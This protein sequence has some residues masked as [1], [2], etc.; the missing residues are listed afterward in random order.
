MPE[1][2]FQ[3]TSSSE[4][5]RVRQ[6]DAWAPVDLSLVQDADGWWRPAVSPTPVKFAGGGST[7][8]S[9]MLG[10]RGIWASQAWKA[11]SLPAPTVSGATLTYPEVL[12]GVDLAM[13][14][15][16]SGFS[17]V[18]VVKS[19]TAAAN[20]ALDVIRLGLSATT[21][22]TARLVGGGMELMATDASPGTQDDGIFHVG[23]A[24]WWDSATAGTGIH[25]PGGADAEHPLDATYSTS[26]ISLNT[27]AVT[28]GGDVTYPLYL[29]PSYSW[30]GGINGGTAYT[31]VDQ[32]YPTAS[33][34]N[35]GHP[36]HLQ[37]VGYV[38]YGDGAPDRTR[39]FWRMNT[40]RVIGKHVI[41]A[42][43]NTTQVWAYS[44][45]ARQVN[46]YE[47]SGISS[48]T[49]WNNQPTQG[50][51]QST[52]NVAYGWSSAGL[53]GASSCSTGGH[54]VGFAATAAV[55]KAAAARA[56]YT[57]LEL[58]AND[59]NDI[60]GWKK[61][62][63]AATLV[64]TY[65]TAPM[66]PNSLSTSAG[67]ACV[68]GAGRP[69]VGSVPLLTA[70]GSDSDGGNVA[71]TFEWWNTGGSRVGYATTAAKA[72]GSAF[73]VAIPSGLF[74]NNANVSWRVRTTDGT[75]VSAFTGFCEFHLDT[76]APLIPSVTSPVTNF[77]DDAYR[78]AHGT[79]DADMNY[80][81]MPPPLTVGD[82]GTLTF[83]SGGSGGS[84]GTL[85]EK[86]YLYSVNG[87]P[88]ATCTPAATGGSCSV[89][90]APGLPSSWVDVRSV[91]AA[92]NTSGVKH[93]VFS[94]LS[95]SILKAQWKIFNSTYWP[96]GRNEASPDE[97]WHN[98]TL[99]SPKGTGG[100]PDR[101]LTPREST[102]TSS[103]SKDS[104]GATI[105]ITDANSG[106]SV[107]NY[108]NAYG[109]DL[110]G[111]NDYL[112]FPIPATTYSQPLDNP[113]I[114]TYHTMSVAAE[115][116]P[117]VTDR[118]TYQTFLSQGGT[119]DSAF[120]LQLDPAG[121][122]RFVT[123]NADS[124][125]RA[126][127]VATAT[128]ATIRAVCHLSSSSSAPDYYDPA[129]WHT[130]VGVMEQLDNQIAIYIDGCGVPIMTVD[131]GGAWNAR[132]RLM[133]GTAWSGGGPS[134]SNMFGGS[135]RSVALY[136]R[137]VTGDQVV[138]ELQG[139]QND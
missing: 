61:F 74:A 96:P 115:V 66:T 76:A 112:D 124:P 46:L 53:G 118:G 131:D 81:D 38:N 97:T 1:G 122:Y 126:I 113:N 60:Y 48:G 77:P 67:T 93:Y 114:E 105:T 103:I 15:T 19:A 89:T 45:S 127:T 132:G 87:R 75:D 64:I 84:G 109:V 110:D 99:A 28:S 8:L 85:D 69:A 108:G 111:I 130:V 62:K 56:G 37:H 54:A 98:V 50:P 120:Y 102:A 125:S 25:G 86:K 58:K 9:S 23:G 72:S 11:G 59:E 92:N 135:I 91:D 6:D 104:T 117:A 27:D 10:P 107:K 70:K 43:F 32:Y 47:S 129:G 30:T 13:T 134:A 29:D 52:A 22:L 16:V 55:V 18:L 26:Q 51:L 12:P 123:T 2:T 101:A 116:K 68:T 73:T 34:W 31:Y 79:T 121:N 5:V 21:P 49:T 3:L 83:G 40:D 88:N 7:A 65:N 94:L 78:G 4:P 33:F 71:L 57:T 137:A 119:S 36:D 14:A 80:H 128:P 20:P 106:P 139:A 44:C 100:D 63:A 24:S 35:G 133:V 39:A 138:N 42:E 82:S 136:L 17:E 95:N 41:S 90:V